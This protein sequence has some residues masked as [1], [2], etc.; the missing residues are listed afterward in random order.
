MS[1]G[2]ERQIQQ[3]R[4]KHGWNE[5]PAEEGKSLW[6]LIGKLLGFI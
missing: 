2:S 5:L 4:E 6:E 3:Q 1:L